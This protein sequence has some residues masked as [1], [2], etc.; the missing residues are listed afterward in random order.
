MIYALFPLRF[1]TNVNICYKPDPSL[2]LTLLFQAI[3]KHSILGL[4]AK[5]DTHNLP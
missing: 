4:Y 2:T 3:K 1:V 5:L